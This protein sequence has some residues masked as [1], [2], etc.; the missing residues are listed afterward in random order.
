MCNESKDILRNDYFIYLLNFYK[1]EFMLYERCHAVINHN[2]QRCWE[3]ISIMH[4]IFLKY[5]LYFFSDNDDSSIDFDS[6]HGRDIWHS[7][8]EIRKTFIMTYDNSIWENNKNEC[9]KKS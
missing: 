9:D 6:F 3:A 8:Y 2:R 5:S 1:N 7:V 4:E